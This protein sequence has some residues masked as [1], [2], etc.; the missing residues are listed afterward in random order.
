MLRNNLAMTGQ[1]LQMSTGSHANRRVGGFQL[2]NPPSNDLN[3]ARFASI[4]SRPRVVSAMELIKV[5]DHLWEI[6]K[7]GAMLVQGR[8]SS[9]P[10]T[11][12]ALRDDPAR[13]QHETAMRETFGSFRHWSPTLSAYKDVADVEAVMEAAGV[14]QK[15]GQ[16]EPSPSSKANSYQTRYMK[17]LHT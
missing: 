8:I 14:T 10:Q 4:L 5:H 13:V 12:E 7:Q 6:P 15:S 9:N 2:P 3:G 17:W 1:R 11:I 16:I